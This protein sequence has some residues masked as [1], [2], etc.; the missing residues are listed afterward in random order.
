MSVTVLSY[1]ICMEAMTNNSNGKL[2]PSHSAYPL[3][4]KC[5]PVSP[6]SRLTI[7]AQGMANMIDGLAGSMNVAS[8]DLVGLQ[9]ASRWGEL[10]HAA[11]KSLAT[12]QS[13]GIKPKMSEMVSFYNPTKF[14]LTKSKG[15]LLDNQDRPFLILVLQTVGQSSG[16]IF[17]NIHAPHNWT[18]DGEYGLVTFDLLQ[19]ELSVAFTSL[20]PT[21]AERKYRIIV[22]GDFNETDWDWSKSGTGGLTTNSWKPLEDAGIDTEVSLQNTPFSC[23][24]ADGVWDDGNGKIKQ[25][26][27]G[28]DYVF[29]SASAAFLQVPDNYSV[30]ELMSDHLPMV[31]LLAD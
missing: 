19:K 27:R 16:V 23:C 2:S 6:G 13:I 14:T 7:C 25:G 30:S 20:S 15:G 26:H 5:I 10:S 24:Q 8:L 18:G 3:G 31:A 1:N 4:K 12:M 9:E 11:V 22:V 29:D 17:I 21:V 28:G